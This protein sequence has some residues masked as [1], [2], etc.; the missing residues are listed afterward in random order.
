MGRP[1]KSVKEKPKL[2]EIMTAEEKNY[3]LL[4]DF[5]YYLEN[6]GKGSGSGAINLLREFL[7]EKSN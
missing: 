6:L 4:F 7:K 2:D 3:I 5:A 1:K